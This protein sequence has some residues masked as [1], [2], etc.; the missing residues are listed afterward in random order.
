V[1]FLLMAVALSGC[2]ASSAMQPGGALEVSSLASA[3]TSSAATSSAATS[4]SSASGVDA[5]P[6]SDASEPPVSSASARPSDATAPAPPGSGS[7]APSSSVSHSDAGSTAYQEVTLDEPTPIGLS[8]REAMM[9][10]SGEYAG[11]LF[12]N[13]EPLDA[14]IVTLRL[15]VNCDGRPI[16]VGS[17]FGGGAQAV[18]ASPDPAGPLALAICCEFTLESDDAFVVDR[19]DVV[20]RLYEPQKAQFS[21]SSVFQ[22]PEI[23]NEPRARTFSGTAYTTRRGLQLLITTSGVD[24]VHEYASVR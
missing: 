23:A 13:E 3:A 8:G 4:D 16:P 19:Q 11:A 15:T 7:G 21:W 24:G 22:D 12:Y 20:L 5:G 10:L 6:E 9:G 14:A 17:A 18:L 2:E 1:R